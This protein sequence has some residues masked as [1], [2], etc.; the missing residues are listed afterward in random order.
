VNRRA[1]RGPAEQ[2]VLTSWRRRFVWTGRAGACAAVKR[3]A[4]RRERHAARRD[5][6]RARRRTGDDDR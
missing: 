3:R 2:D 5:A 1:V 6:D 4:R